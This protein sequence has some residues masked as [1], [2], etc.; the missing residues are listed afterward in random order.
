MNYEYEN[1]KLE[2]KLLPFIFHHIELE[3]EYNTIDAPGN[4]HENPELLFFI[5]GQGSVKYNRETY[6]VKAGDL[7]IV[8]TDCF[9]SVS[10]DTNIEYYCLIIDTGFFKKNGIEIKNKFFAPYIS[11][12]SKLERK[13]R[14]I[15]EYFKKKGNLYEAKIRAKTLDII[16]YISEN[17]VSDSEPKTFAA[18]E[19][20]Q[21]IIY[22]K[23]NFSNNI[24]VDEIIKHVGMSRAYFSR[25]FKKNTGLS[26]IA[27]LNYIRCIQ[28]RSMLCSG[29]SVSET[30]LSCGFENQSYFTRTYKK[31]MG[32]LPSEENKD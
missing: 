6:K 32:K 10:T 28:A 26:M 5:K 25:E 24:T 4:W 13:F 17:Y 23:E 9:H 1:H 7:V 12:A 27:Y 18:D 20:K 19:V 21:A 16:I 29:L 8:N 14:K 31:I 30:S 3:S 15:N 11:N 22:I 2:N